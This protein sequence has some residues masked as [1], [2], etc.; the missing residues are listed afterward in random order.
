MRRCRGDVEVGFFG[1]FLIFLFSSFFENWLVYLVSALG[2]SLA[3][4]EEIHGVGQ[5]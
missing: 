4:L 2:T 5:V 1:S 3:V